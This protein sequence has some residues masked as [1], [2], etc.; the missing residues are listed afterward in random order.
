MSQP[1][2]LADLI[3]VRHGQSEVNMDMPVARYADARLTEVGREQVRHLAQ[4]WNDRP[5]VTATSPFMAA[6]ETARLLQ[7]HGHTDPAINASLGEFRYLDSAFADGSTREQ[8]HA[9]SGA[10]W[11]RRDPHYRDGGEAESFVDLVDRVRT[12][13]SMRADTET[14]VVT[15]GMLISAAVIFARRPTARLQ[16]LMC[17]FA[18]DL[19]E[20][21]VVP[22]CALVRVPRAGGLVRDS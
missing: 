18:D 13:L 14:I 7:G 20:H 22:N 21:G 4:V 6:R 9:R 19:R 10:Y 15:H 1:G 5:A 2:Q 8:R 17:R 16:E 12:V 3:M 11:E